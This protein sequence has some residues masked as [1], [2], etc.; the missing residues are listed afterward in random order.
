MISQAPVQN[1]DS[2]YK[3]L[4]YMEGKHLLLSILVTAV[5]RLLSVNNACLGISLPYQECWYKKGE[6]NPQFPSTNQDNSSSL[7]Q[8]SISGGI[9]NF[10]STDCSQQMTP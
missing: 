5:D 1:T 10:F 2:L 6:P 9:S 4:P 7:L 8:G 3:T